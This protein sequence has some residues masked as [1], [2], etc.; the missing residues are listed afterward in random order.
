MTH[1][2]NRSGL[3]Q[4]INQSTY[5]STQYELD[6]RTRIAT[7]IFVYTKCFCFSHSF[8]SIY[9]RKY[10][11]GPREKIFELYQF[12]FLPSLQPNTYQ[13]YFLF[14]FI[15]YLSFILP[16]IHPTKHKMKNSDESITLP[17]ITQFG[18]LAKHMLEINILIYSTYYS[19]FNL[20]AL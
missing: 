7:P 17:N 4:P 1:L 15:I 16:K 14:F 20:H 3:G 18:V 6:P 9:G 5:N 12:F 8:L 11:G 2:L 13:K 19:I 10:F